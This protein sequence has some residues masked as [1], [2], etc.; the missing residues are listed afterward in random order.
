MCILFRDEK[1][2]S[3]GHILDLT[4]S[5]KSYLSLPEPYDNGQEVSWTRGRVEKNETSLVDSP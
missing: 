5:I 3:I 1:L 4:I 2:D